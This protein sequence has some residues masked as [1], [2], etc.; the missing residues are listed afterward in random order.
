VDVRWFDLMIEDDLKWDWLIDWLFS[1]WP[2]CKMNDP[3]ESV[4]V[5]S[6]VEPNW[7]PQLLMYWSST[8]YS[9]AISA[10]FCYLYGTKVSG[11]WRSQTF[12]NWLLL[13]FGFSIS[14]VPLDVWI[15]HCSW[16]VKVV[17]HFGDR[18]LK[19]AMSK[20]TSFTMLTLSTKL[21]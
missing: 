7:E 1:I 15:S 3:D 4:S 2:W 16:L 5:P 6:L 11:W 18:T 10:T 20:D 12:P 19:Y 14:A 9:A 21:R 17:S 8:C 13:D